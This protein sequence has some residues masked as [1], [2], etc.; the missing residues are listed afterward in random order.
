MAVTN[1]RR[2]SGSHGPEP[3]GRML[4]GNGT[5]SGGRGSTVSPHARNVGEPV[6]ARRAFCGNDASRRRAATAGRPCFTSG[7]SGASAA[8]C[9]CRSSPAIDASRRG[10]AAGCGSQIG[11]LLHERSVKGDLRCDDA[12]R[13]ELELAEQSAS[14]QDFVQ[15]QSGISPGYRCAESRPQSFASLAA[16]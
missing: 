3:A 12:G 14:G 7:T 11:S 15:V 13:A 4:G 6:G 9:W 1:D 10:A 8:T 5:A 2:R 16:L